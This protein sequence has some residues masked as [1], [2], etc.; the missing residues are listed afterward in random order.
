MTIRVDEIDAKILR[1]LQQHGCIPNVELANRVGLS[2]APCLRRVRALEEAGIIRGYV[3]LLDP[4]KVGL[5]VTVFVHISL[6][7]QADRRLESFERTVTKNPEVLECYLMTGESDYLL[8]V[9]VPDVT[10]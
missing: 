2:A 8:R 5:G 7:L 6:D 4:E 9:V 1:E 10:S 3:A